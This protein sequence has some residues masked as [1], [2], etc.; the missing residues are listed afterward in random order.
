M[1]LYCWQRKEVQTGCINFQPATWSGWYWID[2]NKGGMCP[3]HETMIVIIIMKLCTLE[4]FYS[5]LKWVGKKNQAGTCYKL[6]G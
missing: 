3:H 6:P 1:T 2:L 5:Q 4:F